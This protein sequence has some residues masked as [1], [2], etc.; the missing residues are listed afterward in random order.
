MENI[1]IRFAQKGPPKQNINGEWIWPRGD[2]TLFIVYRD[3]DGTTR[4]IK[5]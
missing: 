2:D 3:Q 5:P 1:T 4:I